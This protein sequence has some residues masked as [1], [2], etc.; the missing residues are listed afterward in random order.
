MKYFGKIGEFTIELLQYANDDDIRVFLQNCSKH[1]VPRNET[2]DMK[3]NSY[4]KTRLLNYL[5]EYIFAFCEPKLNTVYSVLTDENTQEMQEIESYKYLGNGVDIVAKKLAPLYLH[6]YALCECYQSYIKF[7]HDEEHFQA[8]DLTRVNKNKRYI[9]GLLINN[10]SENKFY[11]SFDRN[12]ITRYRIV[13]EKVNEQTEYKYAI[14]KFSSTDTLRTGNFAFK[15]QEVK[16]IHDEII[17]KLRKQYCKWCN[18]NPT[19]T[20]S[21][22]CDKCTKL[23]SELKLLQASI[24]K[25]DC[26]SYIS[27]VKTLN[28]NN[29]I[30]K[31]MPNK[32]ED[33]K[34]LRAKRKGE[35]NNIVNKL[36][37]EVLEELNNTEETKVILKQDY[38]K[39]KEYYEALIRI[40]RNV[41]EQISAIF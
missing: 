10:Y 6:L 12:E 29:I 16:V 22:L 30:C 2:E 33:T 27:S 32:N 5:Y 36:E 23:F 41:K 35:L 25:D 11:Y 15:F 19:N 17:E 18:P 1:L 7:S 3:G 20:T 24:S 13:S 40:I 39:Q 14:N 28:F 37:T 26:S 4:Y 9:L 8:I 34:I 21:N 31:V 38:W